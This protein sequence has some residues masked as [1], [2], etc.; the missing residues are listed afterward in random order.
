MVTKLAAQFVKESS[1]GFLR[2]H[3]LPPEDVELLRNHYDLGGTGGL[4]LRNMGREIVGGSIGAFPGAVLGGL[5]AG[6][7]GARKWGPGTNAGIAALA[8]GSAGFLGGG[9][10]GSLKSTDKYSR[11]NADRIRELYANLHEV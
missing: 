7:I 5:G 6:V 11:R 9:L 10:Y 3:D 1:Y 8:G 2:A 4:R